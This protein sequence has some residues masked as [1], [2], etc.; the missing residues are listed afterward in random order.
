M[1]NSEQHVTVKKQLNT[2]MKTLKT[3]TLLLS[4][5]LCT[6]C[7]SDDDNLQANRAPNTFTITL[8]D[9]S[10][11][12]GIITN[13]T[14]AVDPDGDTV[15][16]TVYINNVLQVQDITA[17]TYTLVYELFVNGENT[18]KV[19]ALDENGATREHEITYNFSS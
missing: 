11:D 8:D 7:S 12:S 2:H 18:I 1:I 17:L 9:S 19:I 3:L 5:I 15:T 16:Y 14:A 4:I 13:W 6:A 10:S